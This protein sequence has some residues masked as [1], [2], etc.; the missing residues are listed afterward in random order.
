MLKKDY[1]HWDKKDLIAEIK[2]LEKRKKYGLVWDEERTKEIFELQALNGLP[3]LIDVPEYAVTTNPEHPTHILVEGDNFHALSVLSY[4]HEKS[5]DVIYIDPPYNTG[6]ETWKYNNKYVNDDDAYKHSKWLSFMEKRLR[7]AK[8]LLAP[9]G[10]ICATIDNYEAHTLRMIM[11]EIFFDRDIIMTVIEHNFRGR[12][13]RNFA[14]THE[15]ALW[16]VPKEQDL[17]TRQR[18]KSGDIQRNLRRTGQGSRRHESPTMF[19]GIEVNK[20]TLKI[21]GVTEALKVDEKIPK[22][23]NPNTEMV[24]PI[25]DEKIQRRWYYGK[26]SIMDEVKEGNIWA[27]KIKGKTQIHYWKPGKEKRRKSVWTD[28]K[29]DGS[30]YGT[31]LLTSI[32]G[33]NDFPFPKSIHAVKECIEACTYKKNAVVLDFFA[34][35]GTTGHAVLELNEQ[36]G[37]SRQF[38]LVTNNENN[39]CREI[40]YPRVRNIMKG[41]KYQGTEKKL[42][43]EEELTI[44]DLKKMDKILEEIEE[45]KLQSKDFDEVKSE[46]ENNTLRL[47]GI[48]RSSERKVGFGGNLK[49]YRTSFVPSESS[50][51]NKELLT[52]QSVEML[53]LRENTFDFVTE[54]DMW[55]LYENSEHYTAILFDQLSIPELK[56][57]LGKLKKPVSI[58]IFSLEDDNFANEF[59]DMKDKV[60][61][62]S[63]PEAI[64]RV[65]RRIYK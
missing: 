33:E 44:S 3:V 20:K 50:D 28:P 32:L 30:T 45:I 57:E 29:Y 51:E 59:A 27:K 60:K 62:C 53:C 52:Q 15:Y 64:L 31:E 63:I 54:T 49:Y 38:I 16:G 1:S 46:F 40:C 8:N 24:Y 6:S 58:Y 36:D 37:G 18:E 48:R 35:S 55:K 61:V 25:D 42:L 4:T 13:K 21:V 7:L 9:T 19:F 43:F 17:I 41:Y 26:N 14:L 5:I 12:V 11:E 39:I 34:G 65:Y 22:H 47:V 10:I 56:E 2:K 23:T